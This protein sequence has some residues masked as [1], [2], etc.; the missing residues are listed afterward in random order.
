MRK[1]LIIVISV[2]TTSCSSQS[3][4]VVSNN[5]NV[6]ETENKSDFEQVI[7]NIDNTDFYKNNLERF[8]NV[9]S[10]ILFYKKNPNNEFGKFVLIEDIDREIK[11]VKIDIN[12]ENKLKFDKKELD[13]LTK[14]INSIQEKY[15]IENCDSSTNDIYLIVIKKDNLITSK[16]F[17]IGNLN[18]DKN[19]DNENLNKIKEVLT[20]VYQKMF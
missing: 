19:T 14:N 18:F 7:V 15:F 16:Y 20:I 3:T 12:S 5:C 2:L 4:K 1:V 9:K 8:Q 6:V 10:G 17:S 13:L 11:C